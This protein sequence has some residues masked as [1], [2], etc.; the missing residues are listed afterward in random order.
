IHA[1]IYFV[2]EVH[3]ALAAAGT[4]GFWMGYFGQRAAP[5]GAVAPG[6]VEA[7]FFNFAPARV[8]RAV[9]DV[10]ELA[11]PEV[12]CRVRREAS[13]RLLAR[14][15]AGLADGVLAGAVEHL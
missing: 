3:E 10:W 2:P 14:V 6:V 1:V 4:K 13:A 11:S 15:T 12:L 9:P 7:T 8:R 5:M